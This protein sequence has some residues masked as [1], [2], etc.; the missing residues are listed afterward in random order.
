LRILFGGPAMIHLPLRS[1]LAP[2]PSLESNMSWSE[3]CYRTQ[4]FLHGVDLRRYLDF[5]SRVVFWQGEAPSFSSLEGAML[6]PTYW[7]CRRAQRDS[8]NASLGCF[9]YP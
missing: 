5:L 9:F 8:M 2:K 3:T 7:V 4:R 1:I 6:M